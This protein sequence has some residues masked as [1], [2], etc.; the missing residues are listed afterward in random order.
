[1]FIVNLEPYGAVC[2][3][4]S[5]STSKLEQAASFCGFCAKHHYYQTIAWL[6]KLDS[7]LEGC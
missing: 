7:T 3:S 1:M 4:A 5:G 2:A 6:P